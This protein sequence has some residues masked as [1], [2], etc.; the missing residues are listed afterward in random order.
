[1]RDAPR[2]YI[3]SKMAI[4]QEI[5]LNK[6]QNHYICGVMRKNLNDEI[7]VF[8][9]ENGEFLAKIIE[10]AKKSSI[11]ACVEQLR[12]QIELPQI[13]LFFAPIKGHRNDN[14]IEKATE[15]GVRYIQPIITERTIVR[16]PN[17]EKYLQNA[18]EAAEQCEGLN[19]PQIFPELDLQKAIDNFDGDKI[20]F[21][22]EAGGGAFLKNKASQND[23]KIALLIGPE[24]GFS[25]RERNIIL[26]NPKICPISLGTRILRADTAVITGLALLQTFWGDWQ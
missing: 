21:A 20:F 2:L 8:N 15:I 13:Q 3:N 22:D 12:P 24:G 17:I 1:M 5:N 6:D 14:I 18:I 16:K 7:V 4:G 26:Q 23:K 19:V 25:P 9:G 10:A 11:I